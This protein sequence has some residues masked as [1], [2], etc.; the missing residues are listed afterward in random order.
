[1]ANLRD[2]KNLEYRDGDRVVHAEI[3]EFDH[4]WDLYFFYQGRH[5]HIAKLYKLAF[6][7]FMDAQEVL[8]LYIRRYVA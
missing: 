8:K 6:P 4:C 2:V 3:C 1:M 5:R 7:H